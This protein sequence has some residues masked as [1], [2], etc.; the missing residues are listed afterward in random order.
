VVA[1]KTGAFSMA[2][3]LV[4]G[5]TDQASL[6]REHEQNLALGRAFVPGA[7]GLPLFS[8]CR[9][10]VQ[11]PSGE[12]LELDC[13]VVNVLDSG[14]M[15][16]IA[17]QLRDM[18]EAARARLAAFVALPANAND[19][20]DD[21]DERD[22]FEDAS[23]G[24][25]PT[26]ELDGDGELDE[27]ADDEEGREPLNLVKERQLRLRK[28]DVAERLNVARGPNM[29]DRILLERIYGA[30]VWEQLLR[31][32][33][34]TVPEVA[35]IAKKGTISRPIV[36][37]IVENEGWINQSV[38]RR[39]LLSNPRLSPDNATKVLRTLPQRELKLVP[40]QKAYPALV[41]A[42]AQRLL[43]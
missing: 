39:A 43:K 38:V 19:G 35:R 42:A 1:W 23:T 25:L 30:V 20:R 40:K 31:N 10:V 21:P 29:Q 36:D 15:Q 3:A 14:P 37:L 26:D 32:P 24:E 11:H 34:I 13:E 33:K 28:L 4:L 6:A 27:D 8:P 18:S 9:L 12:T 7:S 16:G 22:D 41:R 2:E 5:F 17:L